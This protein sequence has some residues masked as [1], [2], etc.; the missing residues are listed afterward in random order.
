MAPIPVECEQPDNG[1]PPPDDVNFIVVHV[2]N[3]VDGNHL[4]VLCDYYV[5]WTTYLAMVTLANGD[6][7]VAVYHRA[8]ERPQ[9]GDC[10]VTR[11][12]ID[13]IV[14]PEHFRQ[15]GVEP[16]A[17][18]NYTEGRY[19]MTIDFA[20]SSHDSDLDCMVQGCCHTNGR[21]SER[22]WL[23]RIATNND[24]HYAHFA[25]CPECIGE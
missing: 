11:F 18:L 21:G 19:A 14:S 16:V 23:M 20:H 8:V 3:D 6:A 9:V 24:D 12:H 1:V 2:A 5:P 22:S 7:Y 17:Y 13:A 25:L 10:A 15:F 4:V